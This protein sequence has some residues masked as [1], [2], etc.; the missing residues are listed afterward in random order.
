MNLYPGRHRPER[1]RKQFDGPQEGLIK[2]VGVKGIRFTIPEYN[3]QTIFGPAPYTKVAVEPAGVH[4]HEET[5]EGGGTTSEQA[6]HDH[7]GTVP[8]VG[9][10]CLVVFVG[11]GIGRPWVV[12]WWS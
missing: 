6:N 8:L 12:G 10:K 2:S 3:A 11:N 9:A 5:G 1:E 7:A 4:D